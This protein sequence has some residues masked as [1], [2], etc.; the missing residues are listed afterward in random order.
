MSISKMV[1]LACL[2]AVG[3]VMGGVIRPIEAEMPYCENNLCFTSDGNCDMSLW[4]TNCWETIDGCDDTA[5]PV[6]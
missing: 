3:L 6:E 1:S 2:L 4:P 5:C